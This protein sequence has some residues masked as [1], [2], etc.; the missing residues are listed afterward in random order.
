MLIASGQN[1]KI[2]VLLNLEYT[3]LMFH[4][5]I[6]LFCKSTYF[7]HAT[8]SIKKINKMYD[9]LRLK[10]G[11]T[12]NDNKNK[13]L[14]ALFYP[15]I[16]AL[17]KTPLTFVIFSISGWLTFN[18]WR[19]EDTL[20]SQFLLPSLFKTFEDLIFFPHTFYFIISCFSIVLS[21]FKS[22]FTYF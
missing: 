3:V 20:Y 13:C 4:R 14:F 6:W 9:M 12:F 5:K 8:S 19:T 17:S 10:E 21:F 18:L 1:V 11:D 22:R 7:F 2:T 15:S 16:N